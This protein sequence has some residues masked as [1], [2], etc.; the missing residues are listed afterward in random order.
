MVR[1]STNFNPKEPTMLYRHFTG[2][3]YTAAVK[4]TAE[5]KHPELNKN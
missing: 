2:V 4:D 5:S 3:T 1:V